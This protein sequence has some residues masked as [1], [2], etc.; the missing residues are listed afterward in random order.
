MNYFEETSNNYIAIKQL[1]KYL[2]GHT[3]YIAGGIFKNVFNK[4]E[5]KDVDIFFR[6]KEEYIKAL[7]YFKGKYKEHY[8]NEKVVAFRDK[9]SGIVLELINHVFLEPEDMLNTF[10]FTITKV[11]Y[12]KDMV[13]SN[14]VSEEVKQ[15]EVGTLLIHDKFFEHLLLKRLV[16]DND[17]A[18]INY[19]VSTYN[20]IFR[21]GKY[22]YQPC[23]GTKIKVIQALR[24]IE[25]FSEL[26][27]DQGLYSGVD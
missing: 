22:G 8:S 19:P 14:P 9:D 4:E 10:D 17:I 24:S 7:P 23:R 1:D 13:K 25:S 5:Y 21:Y 15:S 26:D 20:R 16:I 18:D 27:L 12:Y 11:A 6:T 3:G 2:V